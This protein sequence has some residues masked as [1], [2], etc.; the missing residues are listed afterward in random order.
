MGFI[1]RKKDDIDSNAEFIT[2]QGWDKWVMD[3]FLKNKILIYIA[4]NFGYPNVTT[5]FKGISRGI[6]RKLGIYEYI[7]SVIKNR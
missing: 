7:R 4:F 1:C 3:S 5:V 2:I 6:L